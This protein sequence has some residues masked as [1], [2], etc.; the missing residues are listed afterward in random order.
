[1]SEVAAAP[2]FKCDGCGKSYGWKAELSKKRVKCKCGHQ[3]TVPDLSAPKPSV[4]ELLDGPPSLPDGDIYDMIDA[5]PALA[6]PRAILAAEAA[7][8]IAATPAKPVAK[9]AGPP[10]NAPPPLGYRGGPTP[11][12]KARDS[13]ETFHDLKRDV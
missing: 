10:R 5:A 13:F 8:A 9:P 6:P 4:A 2:R 12:Q 1:M 7:A 3:M 11:R